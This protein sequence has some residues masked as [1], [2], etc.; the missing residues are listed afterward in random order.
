MPWKVPNKSVTAVGYLK[1]CPACV[2]GLI[3]ETNS[4]TQTS[5]CFTSWAFESG[6]GVVVRP[7]RLHCDGSYIMYKARKTLLMRET[8]AESYTL[9]VQI[10]MASQP[11]EVTFS[12]LTSFYRY[13][14]ALPTRL[15]PHQDAS[16]RFRQ[17]DN[18]VLDACTRIQFSLNYFPLVLTSR[19]MDGEV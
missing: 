3:V 8:H 16:Q 11:S 17:L 9:Y 2:R 12:A 18:D 15:A 14:S 4:I 10:R 19:S 1:Q 13:P 7:T 6:I 5:D